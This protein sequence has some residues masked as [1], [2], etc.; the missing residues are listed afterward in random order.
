MNDDDFV[1]WQHKVKKKQKQTNLVSVS[2]S[3]LTSN[4]E[5]KASWCVQQQAAW[6]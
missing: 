3:L 2:L 5:N 6:L 4:V 1:G